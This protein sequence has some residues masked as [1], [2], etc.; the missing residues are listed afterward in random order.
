MRTVVVALTAVLAL[1]GL[2]LTWA[3]AAL[4]DAGWRHALSLLHIWAG[5]FFL[6]AFPLYAWDHV[7]TNRHWLARLHGVS[8]SGATQ[9]AAAVLLIL[10]G[11]VLLAYA[12]AHLPVLR[13]LH[14]WLTYVLAAALAVHYLSPKDWWP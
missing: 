8:A 4:A 11:L 13:G 14:H 1:S 2:G 3:G 6:V 5:V 10:T 12:Q 9:L 7:R